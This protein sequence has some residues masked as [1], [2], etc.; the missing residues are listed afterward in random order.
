MQW[1]SMA[2][3]SVGIPVATTTSSA[4]ALGRVSGE[5]KINKKRGGGTPR[6]PF[7]GDL[8]GQLDN[9]LNDLH[10][11]LNYN[12]VGPGAYARFENVGRNPKCN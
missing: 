10:R 1:N 5:R 12:H 8:V 7:D 11:G 3:G 6:N 4:F 9:L 2:L